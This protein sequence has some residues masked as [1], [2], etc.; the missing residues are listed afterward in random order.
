M[1][2]II[3]ELDNDI[4]STSSLKKHIVVYDDKIVLMAKNS[5]LADIESKEKT[6]YYK[7]C[8]GIQ[9]GKASSVMAG[10][11]QIEIASS[12]GMT[13]NKIFY[14]NN[15]GGE[16]NIAFRKGQNDLMEE[17][18][19]YVKKQIEGVKQSKYLQTLVCFSSADEIK[20]FK[21]LLDDGVITQEEFDSKK[22]QLLGL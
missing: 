12:V 17:I 4:A 18:A 22:K 8:K 21:E 15:Y 20:K 10:Y 13:E 7:D 1:S 5:V 2:T 16:T 9:F 3:Y 11:L 19:E 6:I 14:H